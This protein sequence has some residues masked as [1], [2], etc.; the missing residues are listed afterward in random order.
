VQIIQSDSCIMG[1]LSSCIT[2]RDAPKIV[3]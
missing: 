2:G 1:S 3:S